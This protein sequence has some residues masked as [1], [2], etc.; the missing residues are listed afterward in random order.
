LRLYDSSSR[1]L[2]HTLRRH[3]SMYYI[4]VAFAFHCSSP[5]PPPSTLWPIPPV[6]PARFYTSLICSTH[7]SRSNRLAL[8]YC[9]ILTP[10]LYRLLKQLNT[11]LSSCCVCTARTGFLHC[12]QN[13]QIG[14]IS[15]L[16]GI[17]ASYLSWASVPIDPHT[18]YCLFAS[19]YGRSGHSL[20]F[21]SIFVYRS[22][23]RSKGGLGGC[24]SPIFH[25]AK[26]FHCAATAQTSPGHQKRKTSLLG[27]FWSFTSRF[28]DSYK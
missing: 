17:F 7:H 11:C 18:H 26:N 6:L 2:K 10:P 21:Y 13:A 12:Y 22:F 19:L 23:R 5:S 15:R 20:L 16:F 4:A 27:F 14:S 24:T 25:L 9:T 8:C 28:V 3:I 1:R